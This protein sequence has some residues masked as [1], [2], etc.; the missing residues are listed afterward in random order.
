MSKMIVTGPW[1]TISTA[2][3]EPKTPRWTSTPV[4]SS[5]VQNC[6]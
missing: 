1:L 5:A 4:D 3:G 6:S 2:M